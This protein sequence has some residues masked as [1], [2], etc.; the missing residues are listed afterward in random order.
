MDQDHTPTTT[1]APEPESTPDMS[2]DQLREQLDKLKE[3]NQQWGID[4][5]QPSASS[6]RVPAQLNPAS[7]VR[8]RLEGLINF[9]MPEAGETE[10][11]RLVF[12]IRFQQ[13]LS[14]LHKELEDQ[15][16]AKYKADT[17]QT[18]VVPPSS[19]SKLHRG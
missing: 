16:T 12:E 9:I 8:H 13:K 5:A 19:G 10:G 18:L 7:L 4:L 11:A 2:V 14:Q 1:P 6:K 17:K 15:A 3:L